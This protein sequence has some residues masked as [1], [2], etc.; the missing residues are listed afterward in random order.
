MMNLDL[1]IRRR[2]NEPLTDAD[3][4]E[5]RK[6]L[7]AELE[8]IVE[9]ADIDGDTPAERVAKARIDK[10]FFARTYF[11]HYYTTK[12]KPK[13][14]KQI[15]DA[16][17]TRNVPVVLTAFRHAGKSTDAMIEEAHGALFSRSQFIV[18]MMDSHDKAQMYTLRILTEFQHNRRILHD[19]G[20]CVKKD[21]AM[22]NF[23]IFD[24]ESRSYRSR[25]LAMGKDQ[26]IRGAVSGNMRPDLVI[27]EDLEDSISALNPKRTKKL[28]NKIV[29]D[30]RFC[31]DEIKN[32]WGFIVIGNIINSGSTIDT[33]VKFAKRWIKV[34]I[35]VESFDKA[36]RRRATWPEVFPLKKLDEMRA[37]VE[38]GGDAV[39][40]REMLCQAIELEGEFSEAWFRHH[41]GDV[42]GIDRKA[43]IMQID[44]SFADHG[45]KKAM[46]IG[47]LFKL[48]KE[49]PHYNI[50][51]DATG[52]KLDEGEYRVALD[53]FCRKC[54]LDKLIQ[55]MFEW[56][57]KYKPM[58]IRCDGTATQ[59]YF[60]KRELERYA[61]LPDYYQ[62]P[63]KFTEQQENKEAKIAGMQPIVEG[64]YL[65][66]PPRS[67]PD[68]DEL[69]IEFCRHGN[70]GIND[71]GPDVIA[72]WNKSLQKK[73]G[74]RG[75]ARVTLM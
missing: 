3:Y 71:D 21:A 2:R 54:S 72:E 50:C 26:N 46:V 24:P 14:E 48:R 15:F 51:S 1:I 66:L 47:P 13:H 49:D 39:Y 36:G 10:S 9:F 30:V 74:S 55:K 75:K 69:I 73:F 4:D 28:V 60:M 33:L 17:G 43:M 27:C 62:L 44:P 68:V 65:L 59:K 7:L 25:I 12:E 40:R 63:V 32:N 20:L 41:S 6:A 22:G 16:L 61:S 23:E 67:S 31:F 45:D 70:P 8:S 64:G 34:V 5:A 11:P 52:R 58:Q 18:H 38:I 35:P 56:D 37:D 29:A 42:P 19:F 57:R 53:I